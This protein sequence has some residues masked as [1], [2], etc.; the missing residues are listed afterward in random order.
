MIG[1]DYEYNAMANSERTLWWYRCLH[2]LTL[3]ANQGNIPLLKIP[4]YWMPAAEQAA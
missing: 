3:P 4:S 1:K 2:A